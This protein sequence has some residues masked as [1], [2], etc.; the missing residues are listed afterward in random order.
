MPPALDSQR[1]AAFVAYTCS[2]GSAVLILI[3]LLWY[4]GGL[5]WNKRLVFNWHPLLMAV[6]WLVFTT[7]GDSH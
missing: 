4:C 5:G 2:V 1:T 3:W 6:A 7:Q